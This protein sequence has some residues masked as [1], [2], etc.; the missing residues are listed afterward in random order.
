MN[1]PQR[2]SIEQP[3]R[4]LVDNVFM[5]AFARLFMPIALAIIGFFMVTTLTDIRTSTSQIWIAIQKLSDMQSSQAVDIAK[6]QV[7]VDDTS[8]TIKDLKSQLGLLQSQVQGIN[9]PR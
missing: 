9:H 5:V 4:K 8:N 1:L 6:V 2:D 3:V 7:R